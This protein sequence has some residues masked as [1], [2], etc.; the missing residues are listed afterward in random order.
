MTIR[1]VTYRKLT[2]TLTAPTR[3]ALDQLTVVWEARGWR[4][5]GPAVVSA[6]EGHSGAVWTQDM[7][8]IQGPGAG[9]ARGGRGEVVWFD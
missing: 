7:E 1:P 6:A 2:R 5:C 4:R 3:P 8:F 9:D